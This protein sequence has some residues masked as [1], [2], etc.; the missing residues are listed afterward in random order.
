MRPGN[1]SRISLQLDERTS[2]LTPPRS[3]TSLKHGST[4]S[5]GAE[6]VFVD[7]PYA[8]LNVDNTTRYSITHEAMTAL[9]AFMAIITSGTVHADLASITASSDWAEAM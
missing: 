8:K 4:G 3:T 6:Y 7:V 5:H 9:R 1:K 2:R